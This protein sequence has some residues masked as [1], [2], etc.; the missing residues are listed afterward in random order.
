MRGMCIDE[1]QPMK[2]DDKIV[3]THWQKLN[4]TESSHYMLLNYV[5]KVL[6]DKLLVYLGSDE[7]VTRKYSHYIPVHHSSHLHHLEPNHPLYNICT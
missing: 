3:T 6:N 5:P 4:P 1:T 7:S 2:L